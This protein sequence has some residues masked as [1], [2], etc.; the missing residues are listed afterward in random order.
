MKIIKNKIWNNKCLIAFLLSGLNMILIYV[1]FV[2]VFNKYLGM[3]SD[4]IAGTF[5]YF[6][7]FVRNTMDGKSNLFSFGLGL[8]LNEILAIASNGINIFNLLYFL[9]PFVELNTITIIIVILKVACIAASFQFYS[10]KVLKNDGISSV[11]ISVFYSLCA[12]A[13]AYGTIHTMWL[14]ALMILPLLCYAI[15]ICIDLEKRSLLIILY[16]YLFVSFF[17]L[18]YI[19]GIFSFFYTIGYLLLKHEYSESEK[20]WK[21]FLKK[22]ANWVLCALIGVMISAALWVPTLFFIVANRVE[23]STQTYDITATLLQIL[24]SL[25]W[26]MGYGIEGTYSYIYCGIPVLILAPLFFFNRKISRREKLF[27][28]FLTGTLFFC[29]ICKPF[30]SFLHAFDQPDAFWYRYSFLISFCLCSIA[31]IQVKYIAELKMKMVV[32]V[33][34]SLVLLY[35]FIQQTMPLWELPASYVPTLNNNVNFIFNCLFIVLWIAIGFLSCFSK[36]RVRDIALVLAFLLL[37]VESVTSSKALVAIKIEKEGFDEWYDDMLSAT[38][39]IK[40]ENNDN[41]LEELYRVLVRN[42]EYSQNADLL[43]GYNGISDFGDIEKYKVRKFLSNVGF[44]TSPRW[45]DDSGFTPVS[46]MLLGVK[47]VINRPSKMIEEDVNLDNSNQMENE[48][49]VL[50]EERGLEKTTGKND[51]EKN[52]TTFEKNEYYLGIGFLVSG[53]TI[54]F[55]YPGRNVFENSNAIVSTMSGQDVSCFEEIENSKI[56]YDEFSIDNTSYDNGNGFFRRTDSNGLYYFTV[57]NDD[58]SLT[59]AYLQIEDNNPGNYELDYYVRGVQ[60]VGNLQ[61]V[62]AR[63]SNAN[64]MYYNKEKKKYTLF[65]SSYEAASPEVLYYDAINMYTL[66]EDNLKKQYDELSK[67]IYKVQKHSNGHIEGT[68]NVSGDK[69]L[70]FTSIPYDPGWSC[71][72]NGVE[73]EVIRVIDG[74]FMAVYLPKGEECKVEFDYEVPGLKIGCIVSLLGILAFLSV[75]FEKQLKG[76]G[77]SKKTEE[78]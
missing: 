29:T 68:V 54:L 5:G 9:Y 32:S 61:H 56:K 33:S 73:T 74:A 11:I 76:L 35:L 30:N 44:A 66:N 60:N 25:F 26:G 63:L 72:V 62:G 20:K 47:Y 70:L 52:E 45:S 10:S 15:S 2:T 1:F 64:E 55:E 36:K 19:V 41:N 18:G 58:E 75:I 50:A 67:G 39:N 59:N 23:D 69:N 51:N 8:G 27:Y 77:K 57:M 48:E 21:S 65:L 17:Y 53:E 37:C 49:S 38:T 28:G 3:R 78:K 22:L 24:N 71:K 7:D 16:T 42:N 31:A 4:Y 13:V 46:E 6:A 43:F 14:D 34:F 40:N 12:Y